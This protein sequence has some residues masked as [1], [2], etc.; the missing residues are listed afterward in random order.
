MDKC[1]LFKWNICVHFI[2]KLK[3]GRRNNKG[4]LLEVQV[5]CFH[6]LQWFGELGLGLGQVFWGWFTEF[7]MSKD[8]VCHV[9]FWSQESLSCRFPFP[10]GF[11]PCPLCKKFEYLLWWPWHH[12]AW[13]A[14]KLED[15]PWPYRE[16]TNLLEEND[17]SH[18]KEKNK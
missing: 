6:S 11:G 17:L 10:T 18:H 1:H 7:L 2:R 15:W 16:S 8:C 14:S 13:L 9:S 12:S 4:N 5:W 3:P